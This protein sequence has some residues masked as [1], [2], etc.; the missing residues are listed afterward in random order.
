MASTGK[1]GSSHQAGCHSLAP[2][3]VQ[4]KLK[5]FTDYKKKNTKAKVATRSIICY[6]SVSPIVKCT[7]S[8]SPKV[9]RTGKRGS[10]RMGAEVP[11]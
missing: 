4:I 2:L 11:I 3:Q 1:Y 8:P 5:A 10:I 7:W 6:T 9:S